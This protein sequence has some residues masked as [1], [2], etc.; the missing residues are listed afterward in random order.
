MMREGSPPGGFGRLLRE[1]ICLNADR[2][3][4]RLSSRPTAAAV[5]AT[6]ARRT[7]SVCAVL[8]LEADSRLQRPAVASPL[9]GPPPAHSNA[10]HGQLARGHLRAPLASVAWRDGPQLPFCSVGPAGQRVVV[11]NPTPHGHWLLLGRRRSSQGSPAARIA[12]GAWQPRR[13]ANAKAI[14][15]RCASRAGRGRL[16]CVLRRPGREPT[17]DDLHS[18]K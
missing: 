17:V 1:I 11:A 15:G 3:D 16:V 7:A 4:S 10:F 2:V 6:L 14:R 13:P 9:A 8:R 18:N 5:S 12:Y